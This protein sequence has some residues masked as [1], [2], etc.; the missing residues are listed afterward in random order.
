MEQGPRGQKR[1][2]DGFAPSSQTNEIPP[3]HLCCSDLLVV[4]FLPFR[5]GCLFTHELFR[6]NTSNNNTD[7]KNTESSPPSEMCSCWSL[8][9]ALPF[10]TG[11]GN[12]LES[13]KSCSILFGRNKLFE[14][15]FHIIL[16]AHRKTGLRRSRGSRSRRRPSKS[17]R[18]SRQGRMI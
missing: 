4:A 15:I 13:L 11:S 18:A 9:F 1:E 12:V 7:G 2:D 17:N 6:R 14:R 10:F 8:T 3:T 5:S 16:L